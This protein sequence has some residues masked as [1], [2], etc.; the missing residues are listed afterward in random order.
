[1]IV[2]ATSRLQCVVQVAAD[3][4]VNNTAYSDAAPCFGELVSGRRKVGSAQ[5]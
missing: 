2:N 4:E 3:R 1:M 5:P